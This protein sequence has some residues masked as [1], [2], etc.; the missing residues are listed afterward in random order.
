MDRFCD[1]FATREEYEAYLVKAG[2][3]ETERDFLDSRLPARL[4]R[5][6]LH[7]PSRAD[8]EASIRHV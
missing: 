6:T 7:W 4:Q 1:A 8:Y 5:E 2:V 3:T